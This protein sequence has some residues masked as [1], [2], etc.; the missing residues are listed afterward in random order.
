MHLG[1]R[2]IN[3]TREAFYFSRLRPL[4]LGGPAHSQLNGP[5]TGGVIMP[6]EGKMSSADYFKFLSLVYQLFS[7]FFV[8]GDSFHSFLF[9]ICSQMRVT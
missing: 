9:H 1:F 8:L 7:S 6:S 5:G 3:F 2:T 4:D